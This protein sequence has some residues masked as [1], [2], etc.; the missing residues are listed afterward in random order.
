MKN[1]FIA[2]LMITGISVFAN[3][4]EKTLAQKKIDMPGKAC[5]QFTATNASGETVSA[6]ACEET[7]DTLAGAAA[8]LA[9]ACARAKK[10]AEFTVNNM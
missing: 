6:R 3:N 2:T 10:A 9:R 7:G 8:A 4:E 5:C 1:L